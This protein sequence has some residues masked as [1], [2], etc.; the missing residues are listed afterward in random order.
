MKLTLINSVL[1]LTLLNG[2]LS[3]GQ[4]QRPAE[5]DTLNY[6]QVLFQWTPE[7]NAEGYHLQVAISEE[8]DS[9]DVALIHDIDS[10]TNAIVVENGIEWSENYVWRYWSLDAEGNHGDTSLV[11]RFSTMTILDTIPEFELDVN[12]VEQIQPGIT[13]FGITR[14]A[15]TAF[16]SDGNMKLYMPGGG[17]IEQL[18]NGDFLSISGGHILRTNIDGDTIFY[19]TQDGLHHEVDFLPNGN[20]LAL[21]R[22]NRYVPTPGDEGDSLLWEGDV[23]VEVNTD[24]DTLWSWNAHDYFSYEDY[25]QAEIDDAADGG[26]H[27][28]THANA[29]HFTP[30][31]SAVYISVRHLSRITLIDYESKDVIW[32]MGKE[33][34]SGEVTF[35]HDLNFSYQHDPEWQPNG[36]ILLFDNHNLGPEDSSRALEV[37]IDFDRDP[38][39]EIEWESW[40]TPYAR[41]MGDADRLPNGNTLVTLG[42]EGVIYEANDQAEEIWRLTRVIMEGERINRI[43]RAERI[44]DLYPL[45]YT[46]KGPNDGDHVPDGESYFA[47]T[48]N[49]LGN[50]AQEFRYDVSDTEGWFEV[51]NGFRS[52][53]AGEASTLIIRGNTPAGTA[54]DTLTIEVFPVSN[55]DLI[56]SWTAIVQ[57]DENMRIENP[58]TEPIVWNILESYPN[59]F[60]NQTTIRFFVSQPVASS[61]DIFGLDGRHVKTLISGRLDNGEYRILWDGTNRSG[62]PVAAGTY[63]YQLRQGDIVNSHPLILLK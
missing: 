46:I 45:A 43:Y 48:V 15:V 4:P 36:N 63:I 34:P 56:D 20:Y 26:I 30:D 22:E 37:S 16:D 61:L 53:T 11:H 59:P 38:I 28:W 44:P 39:A 17:D 21:G 57:S 8:Y 42:I 32:N 31:M 9:F 52:I 10:P 49:N 19:S 6:T 35:G 2:I 51:V 40:G 23:I 27:D 60:N 5:L 1:I 54:I 29:V 12:D 62:N 55:P 58:A 24:G 33:F 13:L 14:E 50:Q 3:A 47:V 7:M 18:I 41:A 25:E